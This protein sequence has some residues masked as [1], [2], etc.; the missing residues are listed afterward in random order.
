[1]I[2]SKKK[3]KKYI[4]CS[5]HPPDFNMRLKVR[6]TKLAYAA[7]LRMPVST[8]AHVAAMVLLD[9]YNILQEPNIA[10]VERH[11]LLAMARLWY[12]MAYLQDVPIDKRKAV[13]DAPYGEFNAAL[14]SFNARTI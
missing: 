2:L 9:V 12:A 11:L 5:D 13:L 6:A 8:P 7:N 1:L 4:V 3:F 14:L 10:A